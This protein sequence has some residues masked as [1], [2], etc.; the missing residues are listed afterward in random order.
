MLLFDLAAVRRGASWARAPAT[1][2]Q[3]LLPAQLQD[4]D[5][6]AAL[7]GALVEAEAK[8]GGDRRVS[9]DQIRYYTSSFCSAC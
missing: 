5:T 9:W 3:R 2:L 4:Q 6:A 1:Q 7:A 8:R